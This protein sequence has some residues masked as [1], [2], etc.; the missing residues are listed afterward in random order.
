ML[1]SDEIKYQDQLLEQ[2]QTVLEEYYFEYPKLLVQQRNLLI[3]IE[4]SNLLK[5]QKK[6]TR[7]QIASTIIKTLHKYFIEDTVL[8]KTV[9]KLSQMVNA[10]TDCFMYVLTDILKCE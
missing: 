9:E 1:I 10:L 4:V 7:D 8:F 5:D 2:L 6:V 3:F